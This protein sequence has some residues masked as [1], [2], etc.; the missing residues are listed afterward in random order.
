MIE[1]TKITG[2]STLDQEIKK[3]FDAVDKSAA[4]ALDVVLS[5]MRNDLQRHIQEDW[6]RQY[7]PNRYQR[8][9]DNP[10]LGT[11]LGSEK[12][13]KELHSYNSLGERSIELEYSPSGEH[14]SSFWS[15]RN[16]DA[17]I[18]SIQT[19]NL[20]GNPP[21]RPFWN[22]F[23]EDEEDKIIPTLRRNMAPHKLETDNDIV[24][25]TESILEEGTN[26]VINTNRNISD[27]K[28]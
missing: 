13:I 17:L 18:K 1:V 28:D 20:L 21:P 5:D 15:K 8:R 23:V 3:Q 7:T 12:N 22:K 11:P 9:T 10:S 14:A 26:L 19:G 4:K 16:G 27:Y 25:L 24:D 2:F 6:Y